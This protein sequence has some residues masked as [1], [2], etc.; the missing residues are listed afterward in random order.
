VKGLERRFVA[1]Q[2]DFLFLFGSGAVN[3]REA[4]RNRPA[5][6]LEGNRATLLKLRPKFGFQKD[7]LGALTPEFYFGDKAVEGYQI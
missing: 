2:R 6:R 5:N 1:G 4:V 3:Q 7:H